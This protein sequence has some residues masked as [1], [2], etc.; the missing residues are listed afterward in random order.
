MT[1]WLSNERKL[2]V[3]EAYQNW[4]TDSEQS[5]D[6]LARSFGITKGSMYTILRHAGV[7]LKT[8]RSSQAAIRPKSL[9]DEANRMLGQAVLDQ[10]TDV[11]A[12]N[13]ALTIENRAL[14]AQVLDLQRQLLESRRD[15]V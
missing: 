5:A 4:D 6:D 1:K 8:G 7:E 12:K 9:S 3:I 13:Q 15:A 14:T 2:E 10:L 11:T